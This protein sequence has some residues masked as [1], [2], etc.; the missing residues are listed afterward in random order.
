MKI[1]K[2]LNRKYLSI[3]IAILFAASNLNSEEQPV[4]IWN[5]DKENIEN[6]SSKEITNLSKDKDNDNQLTESDIYNMQ[7]KKEVDTVIVDESLNSKEIKIIGLYDP[8]DYDLQIDMW[9]NSDGDQL[10]YL[11]SNLSKID[12][13]EDAADLMNI[14]ILTNAYYP[15]KNITNKE[16]LKIKSDWLIRNKDFEVIEE[17]L[18][19][20]K[21]I[22]LNPR[23]TRYVIDQ[24]LSMSEIKKLAICF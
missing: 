10:K 3:I 11:F 9:S 7:N 2:L 14:S 1:S 24:Y 16:F 13:S 17:Y 19:K 12:L 6:S 5:I 22:D 21:I 8:E 20:N 18:L 23:L 15:N 4:D